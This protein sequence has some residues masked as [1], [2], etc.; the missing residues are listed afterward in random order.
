MITKNGD[1]Y[2]G[3]LIRGQHTK[4]PGREIRVLSPNLSPGFVG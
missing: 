2:T 1:N 3:T 4:V